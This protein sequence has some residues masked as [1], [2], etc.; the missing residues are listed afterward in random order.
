MV[1]LGYWLGVTR[2]MGA[3]GLMMAVVVGSTVATVLLGWRFRVV[4]ARAV[5]RA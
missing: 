3:F 1:P 2:T 5:R 4:S